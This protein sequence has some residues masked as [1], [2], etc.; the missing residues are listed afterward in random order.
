MKGTVYSALGTDGPIKLI[1]G[2]IEQAYPGYHVWVS[3]EGWWYAVKI[4]PAVRG[5]AATLDGAG[6]VELHGA[7][8]EAEGRRVISAPKQER[9]K[10]TIVT[11][12]M[13]RTGAAAAGDAD[14]LKCWSVAIRIRMERPRWVVVWLSQH[15]HYRA[16]P[17]FRLE[18]GARYVSHQM[19]EK[20]QELMDAAEEAS[21]PQGR[22]DAMR[23]AR[24]GG[25]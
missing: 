4:S 15:G 14:D 24:L 21:G 20:L 8:C 10:Q 9:E 12:R 3:D 11:E 22:A 18:D 17:N 6:P 2:H 5:W 16:Y 13:V 23:R 7:L 19:P 1:C 25:R